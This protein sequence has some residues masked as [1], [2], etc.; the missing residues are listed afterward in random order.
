MFF[1]I[2]GKQLTFGSNSLISEAEDAVSSPTHSLIFNQ[3]QS[4]S[5]TGSGS[6]SMGG[7][8]GKKA[9]GTDSVDFP[10]Q[11][12]FGSIYSSSLTIYFDNWA[13]CFKTLWPSNFCPKIMMYFCLL[14]HYK[15]NSNT[16]WIFYL[17]TISNQKNFC[18]VHWIHLLKTN[19][20][21]EVFV[22]YIWVFF[23]SVMLTKKRNT[24]VKDKKKLTWINLAL[25]IK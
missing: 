9:G 23:V 7:A 5:T 13:F 14:N 21:E 10:F 3:V 16:T 19:L 18:F 24:I 25:R 20:F 1:W 15:P 22:F 2:S 12:N 8:S 6:G 4:G 11:F 17:D